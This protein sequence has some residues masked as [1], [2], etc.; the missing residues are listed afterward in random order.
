MP[1][2]APGSGGAGRTR[3]QRSAISDRAMLAA[4]ID[5]I[6]ERGPDKTTLKAIGERAGYSRGLAT[7]RF[8]SKAGL[9]DAVCKAIS[10]RWLRY[11]NDGVGE[12]VGIEAMCAA[13]DAFFRFLSDA[14]RD[15][16]VLHILYC[17]AASPQSEYRETSR[18]IHRRQQQDVAAWIRAGIAA[19]SIR[20][21]A[22]PAS[23]AAQY[24][25]YIS[26]MTYLWV[27]DPEGV[28]YRRANED[29]KKHLKRSLSSARGATAAT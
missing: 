22:N 11:L 24:I 25:A 17:G 2:V 12:A 15:A 3:A 6:L 9:F 5:L 23:I 20:G 14:P 26:G 13:L 27:I 19:G 18:S 4:A 7:Y 28:D 10:R 1:D 16:R 21:D 8:G 29:M